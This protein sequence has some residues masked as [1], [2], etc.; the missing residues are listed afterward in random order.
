ML[1]GFCMIGFVTGNVWKKTSFV[2]VHCSVKTPKSDS[3]Y[4]YLA[5]IF[6]SWRFLRASPDVS[7]DNNTKC[8]DLPFFNSSRKFTY[9]IWCC[10]TSTFLRLRYLSHVIQKSSIVDADW[11]V[12]CKPAERLEWPFLSP[13]LCAVPR[14]LVVGPRNKTVKLMYM[15]FPWTRNPLFCYMARN[16]TVITKTKWVPFRKEISPIPR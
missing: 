13:D 8:K 6:F 9:S 3:V 10:L 15:T 1:E 7:Q 2:L 5:V 16:V 14:L 12:L 4:V 11:C